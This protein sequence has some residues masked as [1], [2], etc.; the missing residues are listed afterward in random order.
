MSLH[1]EIAFEK[2]LAE[3]L[4][5][6]GWLYSPSDDGYDRERALFPVVQDHG[7]LMAADPYPG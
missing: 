4:Q 7:K 2:D 3:Y 1:K 5:A 6:Q